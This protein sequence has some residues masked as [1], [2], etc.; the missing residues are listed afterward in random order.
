M[1][2]NKKWFKRTVLS[3]IPILYLTIAVI[4]LVAIFAINEISLK[5]AERTNR[6]L[7]GTVVHSLETTMKAIDHS[8]LEELRFGD[9]LYDYFEFNPNT[10]PRLVNYEVSRKLRQLT[11]EYPMIHSIY[12]YRFRDDRVLTM[13]SFEEFEEFEDRAFVGQAQQLPARVRWSPVR[14]YGSSSAG[15][16]GGNQAQE[17]QTAVVSL[18]QRA[19][20]PMGNEGIVVVNVSVQHLVAD[21]DKLIDL[22][23]T[24]MHI[25]D[26]TGASLYSSG[27]GNS[28]EVMSRSRSSYLQWEFESGVQSGVAFGWLQF[29]SRLWGVVGVAAIAVSLVYLLVITRRNYRPIERIV[30][31]IQAY[32]N[33]RQAGKGADKDEFAFI[34]KALERL[35]DQN[36][37][38]EEQVQEDRNAR[39]KQAFIQLLEREAPLSDK[40]HR[41]TLMRLDIP[42]AIEEAYVAVIEIDRYADFERK[43]GK[44]EDQ[45]LMKFALAQVLEEFFVPEQP[46]AWAEWIRVNRLAVLQV[47]LPDSQGRHKESTF[48]DYRAWVEANL[49]L[50]VTIGIGSNVSRTEE[51]GK[52]YAEAAGVL[53]F[54]LALGGNR[55][56]PHRELPTDRG[57]HT[58]GYYPLINAVIQEFGTGNP[59]WPDTIQGLFARLSRDVMTNDDL[60]HLL[61][62]F[63]N[64]LERMIEELP[65]ELRSL[66]NEEMKAE[67]ERAVGGDSMQTIARE[68]AELCAQLHESYAE[69]VRSNN[70]SRLVREIRQYIEDNYSNPELSLSHISDK[71]N[72]N[73]KYASQ[74]FKEHTG[75]KFVDFVMNLRIEHAKRLLSDT[76]ESINDISRLVGYEIPLSFGRTFKKLAGVTPSE[77]RK[78]RSALYKEVE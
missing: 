20:L 66:W 14:A 64:L 75:V 43:Y 37:L 35:I 30:Q 11:A 51:I 21:I 10:D 44:P 49:G 18:S 15:A 2:M 41:K 71:Y 17:A 31:Q 76:N 19:Q 26:G 57:L 1:A 56:H 74:L 69:L 8:L 40:E 32:Q 54:K 12:L 9:R 24:F 67:W 39:R 61:Q 48:E 58:H 34:Q 6:Y 52:S 5:E 73:G 65:Y 53:R 47:R 38:Y 55:V 7:T 60:L 59:E 77:Y 78:H 13:N 22:Q 28:A 63:K 50:T 70:N 68:L 62:Y 29:V 36:S 46:P 4:V 33:H 27:E 16:S 3:Y 23:M 42:L 72:L 25:Q 45:Q